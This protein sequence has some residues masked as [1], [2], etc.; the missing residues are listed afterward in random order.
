MFKIKHL[1][2]EQDHLPL[3]LSCCTTCTALYRNGSLVLFGFSLSFM[4]SARRRRATLLGRK[5]AMAP[6]PGFNAT[7][8]QDSN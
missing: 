7:E 1:T 5:P 8:E 4:A 3:L 6:A 2:T